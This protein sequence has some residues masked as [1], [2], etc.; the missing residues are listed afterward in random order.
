MSLTVILLLAL[1][2]SAPAQETRQPIPDATAVVIRTP[3]GVII[4]TGDWR[5]EDDPVDGKKF[6]LERMTEIAT[7]EGI[8]LLMNE[9]TN[10]ESEGT[11]SHGE[12]DI[13]QSMGQVMEKYPNSRLILSCFSS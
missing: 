6:D 11:H 12:F 9:S 5:F 3:L 10:C 7:K 8:L 4:D 13:Q 1:W 2:T